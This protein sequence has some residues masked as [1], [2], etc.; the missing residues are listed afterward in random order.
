MHQAMGQVEIAGTNPNPTH[1][2]TPREKA[3]YFLT[4]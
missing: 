1:P 4:A 2:Q 3:L